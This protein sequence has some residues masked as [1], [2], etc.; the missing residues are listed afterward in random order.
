[1]IIWRMETL[2]NWSGVVSHNLLENDNVVNGKEV[3]S[4]VTKWHRAVKGLESTKSGFL[5]LTACLDSDWV[6]AWTEEAERAEDE[7]GES[8]RVYD[9]KMER[10]KISE[11]QLTNFPLIWL[12][13]AFNGR[14]SFGAYGERI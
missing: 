12:N 3:E 8:L 10:G 4:L 9:V 14:N 5:E 2:K 7:G 6:D 1:M 11:S 13:R